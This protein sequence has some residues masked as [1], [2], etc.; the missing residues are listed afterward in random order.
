MYVTCLRYRYA[1]YELRVE[2]RVVHGKQKQFTL[3]AVNT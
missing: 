1:K 3:S 2:K